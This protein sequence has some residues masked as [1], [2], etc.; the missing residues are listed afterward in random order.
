MKKLASILLFVFVATLTTQAQKEKGPKGPKMTPEQQVILKVK[1]M[2]LDLDL[3][4]QQ[5][6][7][8]EPLIR[9]EV[10]TRT[11]HLKNRKGDKKPTSEEIFTQKN[12]RLDAQIKMKDQMKKILTKEQ[13]DK[14]ENMSRRKKHKSMKKMKHRKDKKRRKGEEQ[15]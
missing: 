9:Q 14:F 2:T 6:K 7:E 10:Q 12:N 13:F 1:K 4:A 3:S 5:Q 15:D 8:I 11:A